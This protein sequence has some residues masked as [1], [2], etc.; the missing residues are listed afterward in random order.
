[1]LE[2]GCVNLLE[3]VVEGGVE[4]ELKM[5]YLVV[6]MGLKEYPSMWRVHWYLGWTEYVCV[7]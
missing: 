1:M 2:L 5:V 3:G 7:G 4:V 6:G